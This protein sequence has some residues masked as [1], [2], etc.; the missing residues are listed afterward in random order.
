[1]IYTEEH[2]QEI[3]FPLGGIGNGAVGLAGNGALIDWEI[4]NRP[5]KGS[6]NPFTFFAIRALY[7]DGKSDTRVLQGDTTHAL[8]GQLGGGFG[9]GPQGGTMCGFPHFR[10]VRFDGRFPLATL[11]FTDEDF[12]A[13]V[14]LEAFS[15][16]IPH[17]DTSSSLPVAL[18]FWHVQSH[19]PGVTYT[20]TFSASN[21]FSP[22][23]NI[24]QQEAGYTAVML[25]DAAKG[26]DEQ[27]YGDLT[28]A[29]DAPDTF[30]QAYWYRG[31]W[32][33]NVATFWR[34]F[35]EGALHS[36]QYPEPG[37][38]DVATIGA[39]VP[40]VA[41]GET[42]TVRFAL[43]WNVPN[44]W[45]D[46]S[47]EKEDPR[48]NGLWKNYYATLF[49]HSDA[50]ARHALAQADAW[51]RATAQFCTSLHSSTADPTVLDA[52][53]ATL[54]V[55]RSPTVLRLAD[56]RLWGWEGVSEKTGSC[57]GTCTPVWSYA[58]ALCFLFPALE[59][60]IRETEFLCDTDAY[61]GM[62]FRTP[63]PPERPIRPFRACLDGQMASVIK[64]YRE[65]K[66]SGDND[67]LRRY[68]PTIK[69]LLEYAWDEHNADQWDRDRDG[70]LE[71]RQHHTLDMELFGP[72][73]W[74]EGMY[75]AALRAGEE[76]A[77]FLCD[78]ETA[79]EYHR[80]FTQ[81]YTYT[82]EKL[83]NGQYY[84]QQIDIHDPTYTERFACPHYWNDEKKQLKYQIGEGCEIDQLLGQWHATLCGLGDIFDPAQRKAALSYM[85]AHLYKPTMRNFPNAWR[86]FALNDEGG[87][88]M[89]DYPAG[90]ERPV[91]PIPY[92]DECMT[93]FE[94]AFAGLLISEGMEQEGL[95][96]I[97]A[98]RDR[99]DGKKRNPWNEIE[100]G[101]NYARPM[102]SFACLMLLSGF[103]YDL[104]HGYMGFAPRCAGNFRCLWSLGQ[105]WGDYLREE[106]CVRILL[107]GGTL[108]LSSLRP[109]LS[110]PVHAVLADGQPCA[111]RQEGDL[112]HFAPL[113]L[114]HELILR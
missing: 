15:P 111:F 41:E 33:D 32:Q 2:L 36:R 25:K 18:F 102:S 103:T 113:T 38:R 35:S 7:P 46:W 75:L 60:S 63:L 4:F 110:T 55:L 74:L 96:V 42:A 68:Y 101:S 109:G 78:T 30:Y 16:F 107:H 80:L 50:T 82:K 92:S 100:C 85:Y 77:R 112:L 34:E 44:C 76:M 48:Y 45:N 40:T 73:A 79:Q 97:R 67:W 87:T 71:G 61:G 37:K 1:M 13:T 39:A 114:S 43:C 8:S 10:H 104:P 84:I 90:A 23:C 31:A 88:V 91:I 54:S 108:T 93:G 106:G 86:V 14:T 65:W 94:Y 26:E 19:V 57:E 66:I 29:T 69:R 47:P 81:G 62:R 98:I 59:R 56:G 70:V 20:L 21:P 12:P 3:S 51:Y 72:S 49:P 52:V 89:C 53:S 95:T 5:N 24:P 28:I 9:Y 58:Y 22:S 11:T 17:D 83:Y 105:A 27:G 99:Y 6:I 64:T